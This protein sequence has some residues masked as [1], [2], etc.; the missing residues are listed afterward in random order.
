LTIEE[1][2]VREAVRDT[3]ARYNHAGDRGQLAE[4]A[5]CFAEDGVLEV[6]NRFTATG[7]DAIVTSLKTV[8]GELTHHEPPPGTHHIVRHYV[9]NLLFT[10]VSPTRIESSAYYVVFFADAPDHWG[11]Y[12]DVL[13]PVDDR[14]LF[15]HRY[16][17]VDGGRAEGLALMTG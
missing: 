7:R 2:L 6:R 5:A 16:V 10:H 17:T 14:W 3:Y 15:A 12:R 9:A 4:L 8:A 1:L 13:V 11:R